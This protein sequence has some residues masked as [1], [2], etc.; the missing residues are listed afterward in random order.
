MNRCRLLTIDVEDWFHIC[1]VESLSDLDSWSGFESR[2]ESATRW[3][4]DVLRQ[5]NIKGIF[6]ILGWIAQEYPDLIREIKT[7]G[8]LIGSHSF[9]HNLLYELSDA[10]FEIDLLKSLDAIDKAIGERPSLYRAPGFSLTHRNFSML[11]ILADNGIEFD[12]SIYPGDRAH[13]GFRTDMNEPYKIMFGGGLSIIEM[14]MSVGRLFGKLDVGLGGGYYRLLPVFILK[15]LFGRR[16]Y[17]MS[18]FHPRD[19]DYGQPKIKGLKFLKSFKTYVGLK[20]SQK[21]FLR[22][23][24]AFSF[25]DPRYSLQRVSDSDLK[26]TLYS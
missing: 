14:P 7:Q 24:D 8:H 26:L 12:F 22:L 10:E 11:Q 18:Y 15:R 5:R 25:D 4:L 9:G 13:G 1:E 3:L 6:F 2:V 17:Q 21:K 20:T 16:E 23:L 19:F